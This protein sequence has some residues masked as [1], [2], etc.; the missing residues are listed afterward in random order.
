M[1]QALILTLFAALLA[2]A[3]TSGTPTAQESSLPVREELQLSGDSTF[4]GLACEGSTDSILIV[5]PYS[6]SDPDTFDIIEARQAHRVFGLPTIGDELAIIRNPEDSTE[7][8]MVINLERLKGE[9]CYMVEPQLRRPAN[10]DEKMPPLPDSLRR[11]WLQPKEYGIDIRRENTVRAIGGARESHS[12]QPSPVTYPAQKRYRQWHI[13]N[14]RLLLSETYRD[15]LGNQTVAATDTADI[16]LLRRDSLVLR[17][18]DHE[19]GYY[20]KQAAQ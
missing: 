19:Q 1:K 11:K 16:V 14:G 17:F 10:A 4:Y 3:C 12:K 2:A 20:R 5:L 7:A 9:W 15:S 13:L 8:L 18:S 6:F